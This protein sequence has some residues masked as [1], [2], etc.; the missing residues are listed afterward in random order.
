VVFG[1][2]ALVFGLD[3]DRRLDISSQ[4]KSKRLSLIMKNV[5]QNI[6]ATAH[7]LIHN[8]R[9]LA[10]IFVTWF[11]LLGTL[12]LF[13][14]TRE[15][16]IR[17]VLVTMTTLVVMPLLFF[18]L[19]AMCVTFTD[20]S[21]VREVLKE[22]LAILRKL[23]VVTIPFILLGVALYLLMG[24]IDAWFSPPPKGPSLATM[25]REGETWLQVLF[26]ATRL[27]LFGVVFPIACIHLWIAV[28]RHTLREVLS[29]IKPI[30]S[31]AFSLRSVKTYVMGFVIFG[32]VPYLLTMIRTP[33]DRAW[34]EITFFG[35]RV[36]M[37]LSIMLVG[38][39]VTVG[40]MQ[41]V[42][43]EVNS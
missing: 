30:F 26:S 40:A 42:S 3:D 11:A 5:L 29:T 28:R 2:R 12:A 14:M 34:L 10:L 36:L 22:A 32:I 33:F 27:V 23:A 35:V 20:S 6:T 37:A 41:R 13:I 16:T 21:A 15:A 8:G 43:A 24:K 19:Q 39:V 25:V 4:Y 18:L 38:W 7:E 9:F 31:T 17:D 1:L